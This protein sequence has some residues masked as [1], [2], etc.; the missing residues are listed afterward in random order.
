[1]LFS[2]TGVNDATPSSNRGN[3]LV[4]P[5]GK[6]LDYRKMIRI[7][8]EKGLD[9]VDVAV[10]GDC[11]L[12]VVI[13]Q[14]QQ[15]GNNSYDVMMLRRWAVE[16]LKI[17]TH[18]VNLVMINRCYSGDIKAYLKE[19]AVQGTLCEGAMLHAV[20]VVTGRDIHLF[21]DNGDVTKFESR[22]VYEGKLITI[23]LVAGVHYVS[24]EPRDT[25]SNRHPT[26]ADKLPITSGSTA[27][28]CHRYKGHKEDQGSAG[29]QEAVWRYSYS[30]LEC[31][32]AKRRLSIVDV[33]QTNALQAVFHQLVLQNI[34]SHDAT[35]LL[36]RAEDYL[37]RQCK[38][39][40]LR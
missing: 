34:K 12:H 38:L 8:E 40:L 17:N 14:L 16:H 15:Q 23:G 20:A 36:S 22:E 25:S 1:M 9:V 6:E 37:T 21:G 7:A 31:E 18:L 26:K 28:T 19:Q 4:N 5:R 39:T 32:A 29:S 24:L 2:G 27:A 13:R 11:A 30:K 33:P 35:L 3:E 10:D